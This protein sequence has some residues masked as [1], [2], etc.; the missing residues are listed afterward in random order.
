M[1]TVKKEIEFET[2]QVPRTNLMYD[3]QENTIHEYTV[4]NDDF[5]TKKPV[6]MSNAAF[7]AE[8]AFW[9]KLEAYELVE[10]YKKE[11][12]KGRLKDIAAELEE[13]SNPVIMIA[14]NKK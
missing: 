5:T 14:K 11:E 2:R 8:I 10:S 6:N 7:N 3:R 9:Q 4:Y 1:Q 12:L 13:E